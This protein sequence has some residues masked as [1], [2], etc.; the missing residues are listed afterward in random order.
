[1]LFLSLRPRDAE[2]LAEAQGRKSKIR[3]SQ[4]HQANNVKTLKLDFEL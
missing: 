3:R 2:A 4:S 1:V